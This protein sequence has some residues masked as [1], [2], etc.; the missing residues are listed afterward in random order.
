MSE[1]RI[2]VMRVPVSLYV[3]AC[4]CV[5]TH[6]LPGCFNFRPLLCE[7]MDPGGLMNAAVDSQTSAGGARVV[8]SGRK[9]RVRFCPS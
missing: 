4:A 6:S 5:C 2:A 3:P 7:Q 9:G 1:P 8:P